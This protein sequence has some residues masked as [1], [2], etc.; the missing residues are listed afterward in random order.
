MRQ[1]NRESLEATGETLSQDELK[2]MRPKRF[3]DSREFQDDD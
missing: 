2:E 3:L 1:L